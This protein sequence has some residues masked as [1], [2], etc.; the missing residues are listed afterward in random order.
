MINFIRKEKD[1][2]NKTI[3]VYACNECGKEIK[4]YRAINKP[5]AVP[6]CES[7]KKK[8]YNE[9]FKRKLAAEHY[10]RA[11]SDVMT[12]L[13]MGAVELPDKNYKELMKLMQRLIKM[14][15]NAAYG[16]QVTREIKKGKKGGVNN[17]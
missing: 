10:T 12:A 6:R 9:T 13:G 3:Y 1:S 7:C 17:V 14:E 4:K 5:D 11:I 15:L 8:I 16:R 2:F